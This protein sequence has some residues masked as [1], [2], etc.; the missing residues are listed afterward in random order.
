MAR[1][2]LKHFW[3]NKI[4]KVKTEKNQYNPECGSAE[5]RVTFIKTYAQACSRRGLSD[6]DGKLAPRV[7]GE[8]AVDGSSQPRGGGR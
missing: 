8:A 5:A 2:I 6:E 4:T 7:S 3:R 1:K